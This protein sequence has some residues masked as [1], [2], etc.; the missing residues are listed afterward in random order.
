MATPIREA[1]LAAVADRLAA[2]IVG[3]PVERARRAAVDI[4]EYPRLVLQGMEMVPDQS[5]S[6]GLTFW[7][8]R[9]TITGYVKGEGPSADLLAEQRL[10]ALH[11]QVSAA[12]EGADLGPCTVQ[13]TNGQVDFVMLD[14]SSSSVASGYFDVGFEALAI[15]P[16][17]SPYATTT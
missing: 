2:S 4:S 8:V 12:L 15:T 1:V 14:A 10:S 13:A 7:T 5:Q 3:V 17:A 9:F 11:A 6:P 16:T